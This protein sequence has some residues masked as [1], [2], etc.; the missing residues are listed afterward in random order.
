MVECSAGSE[1]EALA[2]FPFPPIT[3]G[4]A[5]RYSGRWFQNRGGF[6]SAF[7]SNRIGRELESSV[8][9]LSDLSRGICRSWDGTARGLTRVRFGL[10]TGWMDPL[11]Q[12][13]AG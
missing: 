6:G 12:D 11:E 3:I 2:C 5:A 9:T 1:S 7:R 8:A 13:W 10:L 4:E